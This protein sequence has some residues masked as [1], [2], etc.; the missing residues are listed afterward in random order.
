MITQPN[1]ENAKQVYLRLNAEQRTRLHKNLQVA[2][3]SLYVQSS[4]S[5]SFLAKKLN[6]TH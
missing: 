5:I 2:D 4:Q 6:T 1:F 3:K